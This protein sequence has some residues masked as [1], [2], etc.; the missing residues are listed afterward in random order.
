M[1]VA[2]THSATSDAFLAAI[3]KSSSDAIITEDLNGIITSWNSGAERLYGYAASDVLGKPISVLFPHDGEHDESEILVRINRGELVEHYE[4]VR[5]RKDGT[6]IDI[7]LTVSPLRDGGGVI[8]GASKIARDITSHKRAAERF[9]VTLASI[10]DAV[11]ATDMEGRITFINEVAEKLTGW[12]APEALRQPLD[13]VFRI[14]NETTRAVVESPVTK[15]LR[16]GHTVGLANHTVLLARNGEEH[17]IDDSAAPIRTDAG[18]MWG[19]VLVFRDV[20][21]RRAAEIATLRL[22]AIVEGSDDAIIGKNLQGRVTSWNPGAERLF[23]YGEQEML[24]QSIMRLLPPERVQEE[25][26]ILS[27][28]QRGERVDHFETRRIRKDGTAVEVS[29]TISPIRDDEGHIIGASKIARDITALRQAQERLKAHAEELETQVRERTL[30]LEHMVAELESFSYSLSHD[31]R[32]PIRAIQSFTEIVLNE[33]GEKIPEATDYLQRVIKA[34]GRMDRLVQDVLAFARASQTDVE[35]APIDVDKM[36]RDLIYERPELHPPKANVQVKGQ[37]PQVLGH[38]ASLTQILANL[39]HNAVKFVA[40][41]VTPTV[42]VF[43][44]PAGDKVRIAIRDNGIGID[45]QSQERLFA[46]FQ[47]LPT[48]HPYQGTGVGLAIVRKAAQRMNGTVGLES[49]PGE[50]STF[51]VELPKAN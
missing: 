27:R 18:A 47:R 46:V 16:M 25:L 19:V 11:I 5:R 45:Q 14:V 32:A 23:G 41:G 17:P 33:H 44:Q 26:D 31:M 15:V 20:S 1:P 48:V 7:S 12:S 39:L 8:L 42:E 3:V 24:G 29:L 50:G 21:E 4:T 13:H 9:K 6:L 2:R 40:P 10:G 36:V 22:A 43:A 35:L 30:K 37:L 51:W 49:K 34:A 38:D 28:L